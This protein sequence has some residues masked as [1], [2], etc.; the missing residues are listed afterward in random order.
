M[1]S[2]VLIKDNS[3]PIYLMKQMANGYFRVLYW[4]GKPGTYR[5]KEIIIRGYVILKSDSMVFIKVMEMQ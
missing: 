1:V 3:Y 4:D 2:F 5:I